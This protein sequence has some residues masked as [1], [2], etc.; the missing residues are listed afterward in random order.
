M[1][2]IKLLLHLTKQTPVWALRS[3]NIQNRRKTLFS[4]PFEDLDKNDTLLKV[5]FKTCGFSVLLSKDHAKR[6]V[7]ALEHTGLCWQQTRSSDIYCLLIAS[8]S[9]VLYLISRCFT[10]QYFMFINVKCLRIW[11][12]TGQGWRLSQR[13][14]GG[15]NVQLWVNDLFSGL[16]MGCML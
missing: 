3:E 2:L 11:G 12:F 14:A 1:R 5:P 4:G 6:K 8:L 7:P 16:H 9:L 10:Q 15:P 13:S